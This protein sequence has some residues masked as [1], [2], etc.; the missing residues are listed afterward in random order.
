VIAAGW[1]YRGRD[2][3]NNPVSSALVSHVVIQE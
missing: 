2:T 3:K 1:S